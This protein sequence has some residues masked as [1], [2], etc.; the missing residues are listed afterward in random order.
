MVD[1]DPLIRAAAAFL[2]SQRDRPADGDFWDLYAEPWG[3]SG[4]TV[5]KVD[6]DL[7]LAGLVE[8]IMDAHSRKQDGR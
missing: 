4:G 8:A 1:H 5:Y 7:D 6:G 2:D 3:R